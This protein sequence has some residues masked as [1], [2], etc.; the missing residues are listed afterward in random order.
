MNAAALDVLRCLDGEDCALS[1]TG[2]IELLPQH[3]VDD[4]K[5]VTRELF[6]I[7]RIQRLSVM[8]PSKRYYVFYSLHVRTTCFVR[9]PEPVPQSVA[10]PVLVEAAA[11]LPVLLTIEEAT[12]VLERAGWKPEP[13]VVTVERRVEPDRRRLTA[14]DVI[15]RWRLAF[16]LARVVEIIFES[17]KGGLSR[18]DAA[19]AIRMLREHVRGEA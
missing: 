19:I 6:D 4:L 17:R 12:A 5:A 18:V 15:K 11:P 16:P 7:G 9:A 3:E 2:L 10:D 13:E 14:L 1:L 8:G